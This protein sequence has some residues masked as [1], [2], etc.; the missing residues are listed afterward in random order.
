MIIKRKEI[1]LIWVGKLGRAKIVV[2]A[3]HDS[4]PLSV[5]ISSRSTRWFLLLVK[6]VQ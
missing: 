6:A 1:P 5:P 4:W 3:V 2:A